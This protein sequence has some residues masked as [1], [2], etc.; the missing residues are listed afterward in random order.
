LFDLTLAEFVNYMPWLLSAMSIWQTIWAGNLNR[1]TWVLGLF[2][3]M[4]WLIWIILSKN[5]GLLPMNIAMWI[6]YVRN[7][8]K[9]RKQLE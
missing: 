5:W 4:L 3:Q 1:N 6:V 9:W 8:R 2:N 7:H